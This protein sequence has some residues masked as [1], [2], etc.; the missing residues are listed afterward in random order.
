MIIATWNVNS[1]LAR[2]PLVLR[3][4]EEA[5]PDVLCLQETKCADER[6]PAA[7]FTEAGYKSAVNGQPT[8]NGVAILSRHEIEDVSRGLPTDEEGAHARVIAGTVK[9]VRVL[10]VY[11][12]NGQA[13]GTDKYAFKLE[14]L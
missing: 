9:G 7:E 11:V 3:W 5:R 14:W 10:N 4:L 8:Y 12:P 13:V 6:F 2:L 1:V